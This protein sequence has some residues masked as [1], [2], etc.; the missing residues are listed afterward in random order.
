MSG[1]SASLIEQAVYAACV[2]EL[3]A[4]KP[5]NVSIYSAG[6]GMTTA[7][8]IHS[9][10]QIAPI[11]ANPSLSIGERILG[12]VEATQKAVACNTNLGIILLCA[13]LAK[14]AEQGDVLECLPTVLA[15][16]TQADACLTY[17]AIR[18]AN[19]AGLGDVAEQDV[20]QVPTLSLLE[21]MRLAQTQDK[22]A[23]QYANNY[24]D[25]IKFLPT[26]NRLLTNGCALPTATVITYLHFLSDFLD[27]HIVR[28]W[29]RVIAEQVQQQAR[30]WVAKEVF[31]SDT[32]LSAF[33][34]WLKTRDI[35]PGTSADLTVAVLFI[36]QLRELFSGRDAKLK[37][38]NAKRDS[39]RISYSTHND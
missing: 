16:L 7:D 32:S 35:N 12:S 29:G 4:F 1:L 23:Y 27:T 22:I 21:I 25:I 10:K 34:D 33:D 17:Q 5:G 8:F 11:L 15:S 14:A 28:K 26:L 19:P 13:P 39:V 38:G 6:H 30:L 31:P 18:L 9:A 24:I 2:A 37:E 3:N 36:T 20:Q